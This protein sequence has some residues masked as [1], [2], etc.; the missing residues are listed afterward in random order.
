MEQ[1]QLSEEDKNI[2]VYLRVRPP[3]QRELDRNYRPCLKINPSGKTVTID[4]QPKPRTFL[5]DH[6]GWVDTSQE[7]IFEKVGKPVTDMCVQGFNGTIFAYGQ[8]GSGKTFT[9]QGPQDDKSTQVSEQFR[10][11]GSEHRGLMPR[12]FNHMF[13]QIANLERMNPRL[14]FLCQASFLEI[15]NDKIYDLLEHDSGVLIT[16]SNA[17][18]G[19]YVEGLTERAVDSA[20]D[21]LD[22]MELGVK[23]RTV[24]ETAMNRE[25]SRSHCCFSLTISSSSTDANGLTTTKTSKFNMVDLAGSER[26]RDTGAQ[27][28][29]LNEAAA[30]NQSLSALG[31]VIVALVDIGHGKKRHIPYRDSKLTYL[32]KDSIG[33][34]S[35]T[36]LVACVSPHADSAG[37]S[38]S[39][40]TFAQR[41]KKIKNKAQLNEGFGGNMAALK[42]E[43]ARLRAA[44][45]ALQ[46]SGGGGA[47]GGGS[48]DGDNLSSSDGID[49]ASL[50]GVDGFNAEI[51]SQIL[52]RET[53]VR[54]E[55]EEVEEELSQYIELKTKL[56]K[57]L[58]SNKMMVSL[59]EESLNQLKTQLLKLRK[60]EST[61]ITESEK[62]LQRELTRLKHECKELQEQVTHHPDVLAKSIE[63]REK[64]E[65]I[66]RLREQL[67]ESKALLGL[68]GDAAEQEEEAKQTHESILKFKLVASQEHN[69]RLTMEIQR[70]L[71]SSEAGEAAMN[72]E[73]INILE[74][75]RQL[76]EDQ[77]EEKHAELEAMREEE[78]KRRKEREEAEKKREEEEK[79]R[80]LKL[81]ALE[82]KVNDLTKL[83]RT[84]KGFLEK[85]GEREKLLKEQLASEKSLSLS[86]R[87]EIVKL[88]GNT[89]KAL[90]S[91]SAVTTNMLAKDTEMTD[92]RREVKV[93]RE[94]LEEER[95]ARMEL[96]EEQRLAPSTSRSLSLNSAVSDV[97]SKTNYAASIAAS[98][99]HEEVERERQR[100]KERESEKEE[101][102]EEEEE[103]VHEEEEEEEEAEDEEEEEEEEET[104][105]ATNAGEEEPETEIETDIE[106]APFSLSPAPL[107]DWSA[108]VCGPYF[109][110]PL[111]MCATINVKGYQAGIPALLVELGRIIDSAPHTEGLFRINGDDTV[112]TQ[113]RLYLDTNG[114]LS[115]SS[116][117]PPPTVT[118][119]LA[120]NL[121]SLWVRS[122]PHALL[123]TVT[124]Q[125]LSTASK[126]DVDMAWEVALNRIPQPALSVFVWLID[127]FGRIASYEAKNKMSA[128]NISVAVSSSLFSHTRTS[129]KKLASE[130]ISA[131]LQVKKA[132]EWVHKCITFRASL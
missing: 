123:E 109:A 104:E 14:K 57:S 22:L 78:K 77:L 103:E 64:N 56:E 102:E 66:K 86:L 12:V 96:L 29:R 19:V 10:R 118:P 55:K 106:T 62:L 13:S 17:E 84:L 129:D 23:N 67:A 127:L 25:S 8:T 88:K 131:I 51:L 46:A 71:E 82:K 65:E 59:R 112:L 80:A 100:E 125:D 28:S 74:T 32:L 105:R 40:L 50:S 39:T 89:Q 5:F 6:V 30:I 11:V 38:L 75:E 93:L 107:P 114:S 37:E 1:P 18:R 27:G 16:R 41:A 54:K 79:E 7:D 101:E 20:N 73:V 69:H 92:L 61:P 110:V 116:T 72:E 83:N 34:N 87:N 21:A 26:Q 42:K 85:G 90:E 113:A 121:I 120:A 126:M 97:D 132:V 128:K 81:P 45:K 36:Y 43:N 35:L 60:A 24:G 130:S 94:K 48:G 58:Q 91:V 2:R 99:G 117:K 49:E 33:G 4:A 115:L 76:L 53:E 9:I 122:L 3:L 119:I 70:L 15:Y 111:S 124:V 108:P 98:G 44:L 63:V 47:A 31:N 95:N 68:D 52:H